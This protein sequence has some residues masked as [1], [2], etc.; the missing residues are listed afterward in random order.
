MQLLLYYFELGVCVLTLES[1]Q[2]RRCNTDVPRV[3]SQLFIISTYVLYTVYTASVHTE[4][5]SFYLL[6]YLYMQYLYNFLLGQ[7]FSVFV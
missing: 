7:L 3:N 6:H 4:H 5:C 2:Y 1:T